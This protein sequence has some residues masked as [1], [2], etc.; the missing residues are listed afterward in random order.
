MPHCCSRSLTFRWCPVRVWCGTLPRLRWTSVPWCAGPVTRW[1]WVCPV[2][3]TSFPLVPPSH[4]LT[5]RPTTSPTPLFRSE[6]SWSLYWNQLFILCWNYPVNSPVAGWQFSTRDLHQFIRTR[7]L[8]IQKGKSVNSSHNRTPRCPVRWS[9]TTLCPRWW[10]SSPWPRPGRGWAPTWWRSSAGLSPTRLSW[11][12]L[13][14]SQVGFRFYRGKYDEPFPWQSMEG[15]Y[16]IKNWE[17]Y[18]LKLKITI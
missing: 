10:P 2:S 7:E 11:S 4:Q 17:V 15:K 13:G 5:V 3:T 8:F 16:I 18:Q 14:S 12:S 9:T 1:G 6:L